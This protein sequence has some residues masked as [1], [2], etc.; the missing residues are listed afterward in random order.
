VV[1]EKLR[2]LR[3]QG[4]K[5]KYYHLL[6]GRNNRMDS[7]QAA[8]LDVKLKYLDSWNESRVK[9]AQYYHENLS[10]LDLKLPQV[11]D[12]STHIYHQYVLRVPASG[13]LME[14]LQS[15]GIDARVFYPL[16]LHLQECFKYLKYK[17]G[18]FVQAELA[19]KQTLAIPIDPELTQEEKEYIVQSIKEFL[20]G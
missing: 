6:L 5:D 11:P 10:G 9:V 17:A 14:Y 8:V 3:N 7:L 15:K 20:H 4:N 13:P 1:A 12:Y 16:P 18:D 19:S 2:I